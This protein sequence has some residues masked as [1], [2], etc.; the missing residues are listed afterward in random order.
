MELFNFAL[1][2]AYLCLP[3]KNLL[4]TVV[5]I[6]CRVKLFVLILSVQIEY[7]L[8][9]AVAS[10][11]FDDL[12]VELLPHELL[13]CMHLL[14]ENLVL[15]PAP[16][17][18]RHQVQRSIGRRLLLLDQTQ[19]RDTQFVVLVLHHFAESLLDLILLRHLCLS[20]SLFCLIQLLVPHVD[21]AHVASQGLDVHHAHFIGLLGDRSQCL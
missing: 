13:V 17:D 3:I 21:L 10:V 15:D 4:Q 16:H 6:V 7:L 5:L 2:P 19:C 14:I 18:V 11:V 20:H 1:L 12:V 8:G 9:F